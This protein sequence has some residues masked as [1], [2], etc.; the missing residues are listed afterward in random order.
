MESPCSPE[1]IAMPPNS[2]LRLTSLQTRHVAIFKLTY[3]KTDPYIGRDF[4][5]SC[6]PSSRRFGHPPV[7]AFWD[8]LDL[9]VLDFLTLENTE[10]VPKVLKTYKTQKMIYKVK[11]S[12]EVIN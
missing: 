8:I 12:R 3:L 10:I 2:M 9:V 4:V 6:D 11:V 5:I 7:P 1:Y